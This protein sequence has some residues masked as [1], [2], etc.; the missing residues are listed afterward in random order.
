MMHTLMK[1]VR[2]PKHGIPQ[3]HAED[4]KKIFQYFV[5]S[6]TMDEVVFYVK[7][8]F[9]ILLSK[10]VTP[11]V[12]KAIQTAHEPMPSSFKA[13]RSSYDVSTISP[14]LYDTLEI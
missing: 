10:F 12:T 7:K 14:V 5:E 3:G 1:N 4:L 2:E 9:V 8:L 11:N 13:G 6:K